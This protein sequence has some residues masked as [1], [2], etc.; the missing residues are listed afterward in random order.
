LADLA[1]PVGAFIRECCHVGPGYH[2]ERADLFNAWRRWCEG[3][4][5]EHPGDAG[6]FGRN[7]RAA[8]PSVGDGYPRNGEGRVRVYEGIGLK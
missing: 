5:R 3:Q 7:L 2:V 1:S 6:T 4:G 8:V